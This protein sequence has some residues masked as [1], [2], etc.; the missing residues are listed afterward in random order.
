ME[1]PTLKSPTPLGTPHQGQVVYTSDTADGT[2]IYLQMP[3]GNP[4]GGPSYSQ[5]NPSGFH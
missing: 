2:P 5:D 1:N 4:Q 3:P